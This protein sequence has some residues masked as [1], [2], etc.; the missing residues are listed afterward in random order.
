MSA[1]QAQKRCLPI[2]VIR[3]LDQIQE[4]VAVSGLN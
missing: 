1:C 3:G 2:T 4:E